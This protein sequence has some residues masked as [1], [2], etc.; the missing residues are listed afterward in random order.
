MSATFVVVPEWQGS[1]SSRA[2]RLIDGAEAIRGDLPSAATRIVEVP[3][4]A[5]ESLETGV[6]RFSSISTIAE[7]ASG[8]LAEVPDVAV[9][10]GGDCGVE[11]AA[12]RHAVQRSTGPVAVVWFDAHADLNTPRF[13]A[14]GRLPR[15]GAPYA[16]GRGACRARSRADPRSGAGGARGHP[17]AR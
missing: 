3:A 2:M 13:L 17:S 12:I 4:G 9:V 8:V 14:L 11:F 7:A 6:H 5:G 10:I 15:D 16:A 1:G